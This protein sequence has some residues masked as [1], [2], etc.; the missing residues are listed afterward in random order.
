MTARRGKFADKRDFR[1]TFP[2][3]HQNLR[4]V[5][6]QGI[7]S[8]PTCPSGRLRPRQPNRGSM[9]RYV[10]RHNVAPSAKTTDVAP[11][12]KAVSASFDAV[13]GRRQPPN[14]RQRSRLMG[15][16]IRYHSGARW[17]ES[18]LAWTPNGSNRRRGRDPATTAR[19]GLGLN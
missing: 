16:D 15:D 6:T 17:E 3:H 13:I 8:H 1:Q 12:T 7:N 11:P 5:A 4:S 14:A 9:G 2:Q 19:S 10:Q 18:S